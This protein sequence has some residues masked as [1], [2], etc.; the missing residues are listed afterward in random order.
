MPTINRRAKLAEETT[1]PEV[2]STL[3]DDTSK[4]VR[5]A[6]SR[7][8]HTPVEVLRQLV[9]DPVWL[10]RFD[11]AENPS[12]HALDVARQAADRDVRGAA[13][14]RADLTHRDIDALVSDEDKEVRV[15]M[16]EASSEVDVLRQLAGDEHPAV[17]GAVAANDRTPP[18]V[19]ETLATDRIARVRAS[20]AASRRLSPRSRDRL[21]S[22]RSAD[23]RWSLLVT[24][25]DDVNVAERLSGDA[26]DVV[27][28]QAAAQAQDPGSFTGYLRDD[29]PDGL[30]Q[31]PPDEVD[32][33]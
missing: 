3:A 4:K 2:L 29:D 20:A 32:A 26:D 23:V 28:G 10:V 18:D 25:P 17:R 13:A 19:M 9:V 11:V 30:D 22:D 16:A 31:G 14:Q 8:P 12:R 6:V 33:T 7:N 24:H 27:A 15:R 1:S 21:V 5:A